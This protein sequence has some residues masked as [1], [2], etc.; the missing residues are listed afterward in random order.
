V[1]VRDETEQ[2]VESEKRHF[3]PDIQG[4]RALAVILVIVAHAKVPHFAGGYIGVDVFFVI[5]G[6]VIT[7]LLLRESL[8]IAE[9]HHRLTSAL[10]VLGKFYARRIRRIMPAATLVMLATVLSAYYFLG[11]F[12][13]MQLLED[14][15][16]ASTFRVNFHFI[17]VGMDYFSQGLP[18][19]L[20]THF[21]SLAVEEQFY[22]VFPLLLVFTAVIVGL[23][24]HRLALSSVLA[25]VVVWSAYESAKLT[26][27]SPYAYFSPKTRFWEIGLGALLAALPP[28]LRAIDARLA[29]VIGWVSL[30]VIVATAY[31]LTDASLVPG[32]LTWWACAPAGA[33]LFFGNARHQAAPSRFFASRPLRYIGDISYSL[34]LFHWAWLK[35][36][37]QYAQIKYGLMTSLPPLARIEQIAAATLCA[38]VSYRFFE[39][40]IR[41]SAWL[42][43]H[44]WLTAVLAAVMISLV[45]LTAYLLG[46]YWTT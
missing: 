15:R 25:V 45:W 44:P 43:R 42:D 39:N 14:L 33:L 34:Y 23:R 28:T 3:R 37:E 8:A 36:P 21:W 46:R 18:P 5:S 20:I 17:S 7:E 16:W 11:P 1:N 24:R 9:P 31:H 38:A 40:P 2:Y 10:K 30:G 27:G 13:S 12:T 19:S 32:T 35:L 41:R 4:L 26:T 29:A 22:F 6:F